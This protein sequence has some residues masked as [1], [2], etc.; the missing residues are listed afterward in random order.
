MLNLDSR[1]GGWEDIG[2]YKGLGTCLDYFARL[3]N[4]GPEYMQATYWHHQLAFGSVPHLLATP[5][6]RD[7]W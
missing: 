5:R 1:L 4:T 2:W 6:V 3:S 7:L